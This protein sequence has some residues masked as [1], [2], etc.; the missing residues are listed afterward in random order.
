MVLIYDQVFKC[1]ERPASVA[2]VVPRITSQGVYRGSQDQLALPGWVASVQPRGCGG[3][4]CDQ[5]GCWAFSYS[6]SF[7]NGDVGL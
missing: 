3:I 6:C 7:S 4:L 2:L 1:W 5:D